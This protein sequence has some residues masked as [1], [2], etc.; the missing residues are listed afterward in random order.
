MYE[1]TQ[2]RWLHSLDIILG[3]INVILAILV[4]IYPGLGVSI[5]IFMLSWALFVMGCSRIV[6]GLFT[7]D[8]KNKLKIANL[9][10]GILTLIMG[11]IALSYSGLGTTILIYLI[12]LG[13]AINGMTRV[14]VG[15][16]TKVFPD[17]FRVLLVVIGLL[18]II[19]SLAVFALPNLTIITLVYILSFNFLINGVARIFSGITGR[20][21]SDSHYLMENK[22]I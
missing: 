22:P 12:S 18:A 4:I 16:S 14:I 11:I 19:L 10:V 3:F 2:Q 7:K 6:V 5:L 21:R 17:W 8:L 15:V 1:E 13:L 20:Q 9:L